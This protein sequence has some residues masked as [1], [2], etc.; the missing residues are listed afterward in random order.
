MFYPISCLNCLIVY[1][2]SICWSHTMYTACRTTRAECI[3]CWRASYRL[4][5]PAVATTGQ[6]LMN[7]LMGAAVPDHG[8]GGWRVVCNGDQQSVTIRQRHGIVFTTAARR[9]PSPAHRPPSTARRPPPTAHRPPPAARCPPSTACRP[10]S[11]VHCLPS[12]ARRPPSAV[13]RPP[14]AFHRPPPAVR[15]PPPA[16]RRPPS[17]VHRPPSTVH[18]P[19]PAA[20]LP[21]PTVHRPPSTARRPPSAVRRPPPAIHQPPSTRPKGQALC[22]MRAGHLDRGGSVSIMGNGQRGSMAGRG[23][24]RVGVGGAGRG[25]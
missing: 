20:R 23:E 2:I 21:P 24:A 7:R 19:P 14:P 10:P 11:A 25:G 6:P 15:R 9:P 22:I 5:S 12:T 17:A 13:R 8:Q 1:T 18:R 4:H 16:A 3:L